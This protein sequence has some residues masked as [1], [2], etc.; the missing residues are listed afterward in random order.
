MTPL[1]KPHPGLS[2]VTRLHRLAH[3]SENV[4]W[5]EWLTLIGVGI[6]TAALSALVDVHVRIPGHAI[7]KVVFP[8]AAGLAMVPRRGAGSTIGGS[9]LI[10]A[11]GMRMAGF[12]GEGLGFGAL[13]SLTVI[14]PALDWTLRHARSGRAVYIGF[15]LAGL[16]TNLVALVVRGTLKG[17]GWEHAGGRPLASWLA[18]ASITYVLCGIVAGLVSAAVWFAAR[19]AEETEKQEPLS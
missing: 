3:R 14:G 17:L 10:T 8:V 16:F 11:L 4:S 1:L 13:T 12:G 6:V 18:Q 9:A 5:L 7:L 2:G 19:P 15:V